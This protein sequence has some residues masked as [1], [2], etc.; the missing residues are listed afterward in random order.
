MQA[1]RNGILALARDHEL[2]AEQFAALKRRYAGK[3]DPGN[4][5]KYAESTYA[6][7]DLLTEWPPVGRRF[8]QLVSIIGKKPQKW[9]FDAAAYLV[10]PAG[11]T[12]K[13]SCY[14]YDIDHIEAGRRYVFVVVN[15]VIQSVHIEGII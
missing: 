10:L 2:S 6:M 5:D 7:E 1:Y 12:V 13:G 4:H 3:I 14:H 15:G 9:D 8:E 11:H